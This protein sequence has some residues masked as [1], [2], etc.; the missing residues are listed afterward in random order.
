MVNGITRQ[1]GPGLYSAERYDYTESY[2]ETEEED[3]DGYYKADP[4]PDAG[5][6]KPVLPPRPTASVQPPSTKGSLA[7]PKGGKGGLLS[8]LLSWWL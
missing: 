8:W 7:G 1:G 5:E 6:T 3:G 4:E 2:E